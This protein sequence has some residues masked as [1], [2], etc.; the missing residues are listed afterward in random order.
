ML[1]GLR[2][3]AAWGILLTHVAFQ[4]GIDPATTPGAILARCDFFVAVFFALSAYLL[5]RRHRNDS[6]FGHYYLKRAVRILPAYLCLCVVV[7]LFMGASVTQ[8]IATLTLTQIYV[9]HGLVAGLTHLWSL[10]VEVA[11]YLILPL[12]LL[13]PKRWRI[14]TVLA[15]VAGG[16]AWPWL[17][18]GAAWAPVNLQLFP[19]SWALWFAVGIVCAEAE[20]FLQRLPL[21]RSP[22]LRPGAWALA[23]VVLW[24]AGQEWFSPLGLEHPSAGEFNRRILA[25]ALF[26]FLIIVPY[27]IGPPSRLLSSELFQ[28]CGRWSYGF[29]LWHVAILEVIFPVLGIPYFSGSWTDFLIILVASTAVSLVVAAASYI[30]VEEPARRVLMEV[31]SNRSRFTLWGRGQTKSERNKTAETL[32][33]L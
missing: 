24:A 22:L 26:A 16:L 20:P 6:R 14:L 28:A 8:I 3:I 33:V 18:E 17:W 21:A 9:P 2:A 12:I 31:F 11:F 7:L 25:G 30:L 29:F 13:L 10:C 15:L 23:I 4:V 5:W 19:L 32:S 27:L 1:Q